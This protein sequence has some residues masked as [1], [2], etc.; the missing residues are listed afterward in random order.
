VDLNVCRTVAELQCQQV[1]W[2]K[3]PGWGCEDIWIKTSSIGGRW[4]DNMRIGTC[5]RCRWVRHDGMGRTE[6]RIDH[7]PDG[8]TRRTDLTS[9]WSWMQVVAA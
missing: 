9:H 4:G 2:C 8:D 1:D 7:E 6:Y 3:Y 5:A